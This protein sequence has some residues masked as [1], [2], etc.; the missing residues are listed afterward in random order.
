MTDLPTI[1]ETIL[2]I[3]EAHAGQRDAAGLDYYHH[4]IAV[5]DLLPADASH[6]VR[7]AALLHDVIEDTSHDRATLSARG[8]DKE[9]LDMVEC[10][11]WYP[12]DRRGFE[13]KID[14]LIATGNRGAMLVKRA[15]MTHNSDPLRLAALSEDRILHFRTKYV[16]SLAK[17]NEILN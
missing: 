7:L 3:K 17:L 9:T 4:P 16:T 11:T 15:D 2:F 14:A 6:T 5:M 1:E 13:E 12:D 8:Y 10:V